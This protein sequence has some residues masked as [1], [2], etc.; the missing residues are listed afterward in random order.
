MGFRNHSHK[1]HS[2]KSPIPFSG[3]NLELLSQLVKG[4]DKISQEL[5]HIDLTLM[6]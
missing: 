6:R 4:L 3:L 2:L 5:S 1:R